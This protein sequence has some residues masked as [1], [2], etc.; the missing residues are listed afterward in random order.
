LSTP[1]LGSQ[2]DV[3]NRLPLT[4]TGV[5]VTSEKSIAWKFPVYPLIVKVAQQAPYQ[6]TETPSSEI[7]VTLLVAVP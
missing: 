4:T 5:G 6:V 1:W 7:T 2:F 3:K